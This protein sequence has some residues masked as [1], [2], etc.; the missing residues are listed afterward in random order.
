MCYHMTKFLWFSGL[1][2]VLKITG[3]AKILGLDSEKEHNLSHGSLYL[4]FR[5]FIVPHEF[6]N[7]SNFR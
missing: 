6:F 3:R 7:S 5:I 4:S 1:F 2:D